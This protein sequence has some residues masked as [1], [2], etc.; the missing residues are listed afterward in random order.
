[1][2][3]HR[4]SVF[5]AASALLVS[6][7]VVWARDPVAAQAAFDE[8]RGLMQEGRYE[9]ACPLFEESDRLA[10]ATATQFH[11]A[12]CWQH[13]GRTASAW[14]LFLEVEARARALGQRARERVAHDR[15]TALRPFLSTL[16]VTSRGSASQIEI[17]RDGAPLLRGDLGVA[18]PV[19]PG[20]H[21]V[22]MHAPNKRFW[23]MNVYVPKGASVRIELP[24]LDDM[25][26]AA[27]TRTARRP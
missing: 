11:L 23:Q 25:P 10:P 20:P 15:A 26:D 12:D 1:M 7:G 14:T 8:A 16:L 6:P 2:V 19:D 9:Q 3:R 4:I 22:T 17:R 24:T 13:L 18:L 27:P 21:V 5:L